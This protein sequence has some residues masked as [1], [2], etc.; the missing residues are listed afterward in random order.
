MLVSPCASGNF[1]HVWYNLLKDVNAHLPILIVTRL[2]NFKFNPN[3]YSL[4][5]YILVDGCEYGWSERFDNGTHLFGINTEKYSQFDNEEWKKF[6]EFVKSKPPLLT[7]KRELLEGDES[8][9]VVPISY[10]SWHPI[11][12]TQTK[13][14]F[15][16]RL[17]SANFIWGFSHERRRSLHGEIWS[18]CAEFD[19]IVCDNIEK[20]FEFFEHESNPKKWLT[21][22]IPWYARLAME[23][24]ISINGM[25]KI[26]LSLP[27][28]GRHCFRM[29]ESP[30]NSVMYKHDD[31]IKE[32]YPWVKNVNCLKSESGKEIETIIE[33]LKSPDLYDIYCA[34]V[35][36]CR[37]YWLP[38]YQK[39]YI[40]PLIDK[41]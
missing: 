12:E 19:Y 4:D 26:S 7:F 1:D 24:I 13:D 28:A 34:G 23:T 18:R 35:E 3:L 25:S 20:L 21:V 15:D 10:P 11:P 39:K 27:G 22:N 8:E 41:A 32:S 36:N 29:S 17:I 5:K 14:S 37:N 38:T 2:E 30:M 40:Q 31:G 33:S 6:D 9:T 16:K